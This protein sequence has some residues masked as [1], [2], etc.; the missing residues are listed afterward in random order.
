[1]EATLIKYRAI[2]VKQIMYWAENIFC[3]R[4][5]CLFVSIGIWQGRETDER[6][7]DDIVHLLNVDHLFIRTS[8]DLTS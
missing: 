8:T 7:A 1:M 4:L 3:F 5:F 2:L 6:E